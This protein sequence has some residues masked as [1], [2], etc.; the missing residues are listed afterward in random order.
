MKMLVILIGAISKYV[1]KWEKKA[2]YSK[3]GSFV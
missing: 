3:V 1:N 2:K